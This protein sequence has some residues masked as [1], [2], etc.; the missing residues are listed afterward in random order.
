MF[1]L[2]IITFFYWRIEYNQKASFVKVFQFEKTTF[3]DWSLNAFE[4]LDLCECFNLQELLIHWPIKY[5]TKVLVV[6]MYEL[7]GITYVYWPI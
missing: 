7:A 1:Q 4:N 2:E 3:I 5:I 6:G